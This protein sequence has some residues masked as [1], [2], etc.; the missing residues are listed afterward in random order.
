MTKDSR[1]KIERNQADKAW[2]KEKKR[3]SKEE[4]EWSSV[5]VKVI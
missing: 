3:C 1:I 4:T 5:C 2:G